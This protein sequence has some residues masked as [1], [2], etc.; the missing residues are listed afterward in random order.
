[1]I[2]LMPHSG[3]FCKIEWKVMNSHCDRAQDW[4]LAFNGIDSKFFTISF[5]CQGALI[6]SCFL[7]M[8]TVSCVDLLWSGL[9]C[10]DWNLGSTEV[11][12][13]FTIDMNGLWLMKLKLPIA[14]TGSLV[15]TVEPHIHSITRALNINWTTGWNKSKSGAK[16]CPG[17]SSLPSPCPKSEQ[18]S[19]GE[20]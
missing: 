20:H 9:G 4:T 3:S 19:R 8:V 10:L 16:L 12:K 1:M 18:A 11:R 6:A 2:C 5:V 14:Q 15:Y 17:T 7:L 13:N